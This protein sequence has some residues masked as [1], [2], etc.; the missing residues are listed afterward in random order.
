[1]L[2]FPFPNLCPCRKFSSTGKEN[3]G[4]YAKGKDITKKTPTYTGGRTPGQ[5]SILYKHDHISEK[6]QALLAVAKT[7]GKEELC[8]LNDLLKNKF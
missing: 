7:R 2:L 1:M 5:S 6:H 8:L 3:K 4:Y